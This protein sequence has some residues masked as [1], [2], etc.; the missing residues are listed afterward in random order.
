[1]QVTEQT[2]AMAQAVVDYHLKY[3]GR[4]EQASW[5]GG[6]SYRYKMTV[7]EQNLCDTTMCA[8]GTAVFVEQGIEGLNRC[9]DVNACGIWESEGARILG[10][11]TDEEIQA[12]FYDVSNEEA[13]DGLRA[14]A[15]G[16]EDKFHA[17]MGL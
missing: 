17:I 5:I 6:P 16:D 7:T 9:I 14:I 13:M 1:M 4:H 2:K 8:A 11:T 3:P 12:L 10:L 15:A